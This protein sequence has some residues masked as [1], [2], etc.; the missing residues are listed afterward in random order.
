[1]KEKGKTNLFAEWYSG[2]LRIIEGKIM[3]YSHWGY[4]SVYQRDIFLTFRNGVLVKTRKRDN[5][6]LIM[7]FFRYMFAPL[8]RW[9]EKK[10]AGD[11]TFDDYDFVKKK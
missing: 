2:K 4:E 9:L 6:P 10:A 11:D 5:D 1:M 7:R 3:R 8:G